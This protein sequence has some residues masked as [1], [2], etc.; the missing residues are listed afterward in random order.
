ML[1]IGTV[2]STNEPEPKMAATEKQVKY[3]MALLDK[4][5][6]STRYMNATF[7]ELGARMTERT[8]SVE[9]WVKSRT[10]SEASEIIARLQSK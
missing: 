9:T 5:G 4:R 2:A 7:K 3:I 8:G 6:Y 1:N 10:V